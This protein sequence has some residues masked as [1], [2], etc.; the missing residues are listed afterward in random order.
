MEDAR[1]DQTEAVSGATTSPITS[2]VLVD[3][4]QLLVVPTRQCSRRVS[5]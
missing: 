4:F 5:A 3:S 1:E 2:Q